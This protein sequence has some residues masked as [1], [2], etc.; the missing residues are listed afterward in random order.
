MTDEFCAF[1]TNQTWNLIPCSNGISMIGCKWMYI[2]KMKL[3]DTLDTYKARFVAQGYK[4]EYGIDYALLL[5]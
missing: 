4:Q 1:E 5:K 2:I 3:D